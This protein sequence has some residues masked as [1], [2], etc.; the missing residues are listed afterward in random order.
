MLPLFLADAFLFG[1]ISGHYW[2]FALVV[3]CWKPDEKPTQTSGTGSS[4]VNR[5]N[6]FLPVMLLSNN[7]IFSIFIKRWGF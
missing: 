4:Q 3:L 2:S 6:H 7:S 1:V 5:V